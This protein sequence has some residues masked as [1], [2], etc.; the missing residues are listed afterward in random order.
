ML[1]LAACVYERWSESRQSWGALCRSAPPSAAQLS[2]FHKPRV[3]FCLK[4][5]GTSPGCL[6]AAIT[7][8]PRLRCL[9]R[10]TATL[11]SSLCFHGQLVSLLKAHPSFLSGRRD[12]PREPD[13]ACQE[14]WS[15][16]R[17]AQPLILSVCL[18]CCSVALGGGGGPSVLATASPSAHVFSFLGSVTA[19]KNGCTSDRLQLPLIAAFAL[20]GLFDRAKRLRPCRFTTVPRRILSVVRVRRSRAP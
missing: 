9:S 16:L 20:S 13:L 5:C 10:L 1:F 2:I 3:P 18:F 11:C 7:A 12:E 4:T 6:R 15:R 14:G 17:R 8:P 19:A